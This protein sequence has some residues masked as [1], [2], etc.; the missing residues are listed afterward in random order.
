[1]SIDYATLVRD[2]ADEQDA[3]DR[4]LLR[5]APGQWDTPTHAPGWAARDQLAHLAFFDDAARLAIEDA[6]AFEDARA[7]ALRDAP[8]FEAGYLARGRAMTP[9]QLY[10]WWRDSSRALVVAAASL[11]G[12]ARLPWF[13]PSMSAASFVT[14]RLMETWSHGLDIVDVVGYDRPDTDRLRHVVELGIR[15]RAYSFQ[16]RGLTPPEAPIRIELQSPS[17][18]SWADGPEH[19]PDRITGTATDFCRAV[20]QRRHLA[21]TNLLVEGDAAIQWMQVAQAFAGPPGQGRTPG[22]FPRER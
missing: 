1:M 22:E 9:E 11:D 5:L 6:A 17:G 13:G 18:A 3:L 15:T 2:L 14:A 16:I 21:D 20:T 7:Q 10:R 12:K 8:A 19:A 4:V